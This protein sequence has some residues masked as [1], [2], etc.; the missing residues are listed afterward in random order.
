MNYLCEGCK[1]IGKDPMEPPCIY[2]TRAFKRV[3]L[4]WR[5]EEENDET[6]D[7]CKGEGT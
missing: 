5:G 3:D 2:C 4:Y 7:N 6:K 1:F